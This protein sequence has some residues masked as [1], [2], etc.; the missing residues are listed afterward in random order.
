MCGFAARAFLP[1]HITF[2]T[3]AD[4]MVST[5]VP[6]FGLPRLIIIDANRKLCGKFTMLFCNLGIPVKLTLRGDHWA[7]RNEQFHR[8]LNKVEMINTAET[9]S[10]HQWKQGVVFGLYGWNAGPV[11]GTSIPPTSPDPLAPS[12]KNFLSN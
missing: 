3:L 4:A 12:A 5:F 11:D 8:Y 6:V 2:K 1:K 9:T 10:Y 7:V